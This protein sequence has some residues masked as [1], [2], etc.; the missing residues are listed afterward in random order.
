MSRQSPSQP[1]SWLGWRLGSQ[2]EVKP[3]ASLRLAAKCAH[4]NGVHAC[5]LMMFY[6]PS[7]EASADRFGWRGG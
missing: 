1:A 2:G 7:G 4:T 5:W 6:F 3:I